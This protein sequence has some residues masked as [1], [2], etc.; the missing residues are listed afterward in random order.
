MIPNYKEKKNDIE[1]TC[2][3][4]WGVDGDKGLTV[5]KV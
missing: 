4:E 2:Y 1:N 3:R 5:G